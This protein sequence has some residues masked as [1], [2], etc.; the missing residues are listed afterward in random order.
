[1]SRG[2][3]RGDVPVVPPGGVLVVEDAGLEA[4]VQDAD[5]AVR[6]LAQRGVVADL[7]GPEGVVVRA[8]SW[9]PGEGGEGLGMQRGAEASVGG[10]PGQ[11]DALLTRG[12]GDRALPGVVLACPRI[13]VAVGVVAEL[14]EHTGTQYERQARLC[15]LYT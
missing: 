4:A 15:L 14:A 2:E 9:G 5:E 10:V 3:G 1:M 11:H 6:Q 12:S 13:G 7:P 8:R